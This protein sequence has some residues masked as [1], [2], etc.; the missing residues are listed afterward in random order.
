M[1]RA[2][3]RERWKVVEPLLDTALDLDPEDRPAFLDRICRGDAALRAEVMSLLAACE[4][5]SSMLES[6]AAVA[7]APLLDK[8]EVAA[9][10]SMLGGRY[11]IVRELGRGGMATVYLADDP[12]HGRQVAV[13]TLHTEIARAIGRER[14]IR[15]IEIAARLSHPH[16]L[17]LHDSGEEESACDDE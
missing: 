15:E 3:S 11:R 4:S 17:P 7:F 12:K 2:L 5:G 13:K 16:I 9:P 14:F 1:L 10:P 6:P 8:A